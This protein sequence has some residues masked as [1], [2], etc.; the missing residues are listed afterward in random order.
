MSGGACKLYA[1]LRWRLNRFAKLEYLWV[2][3][4]SIGLAFE[5]LSR[6]GLAGILS[7]VYSSNDRKV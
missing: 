7:E 6:P 3:R 4:A 5:D 1:K 2:P